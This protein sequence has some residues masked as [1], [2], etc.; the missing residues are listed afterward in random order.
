M[1]HSMPS[2]PLAVLAALTW[3]GSAHSDEK[4]NQAREAS[5]VRTMAEAEP[6]S[7]TV[8][9]LKEV[10]VRGSKW[11]YL[12]VLLE[13]PEGGDVIV[14]LGRAD[15]LSELGIR[16]GEQL[17]GEGHSITL[18]DNQVVMARQVKV[19]DQTVKIRRPAAR[20]PGTQALPLDVESADFSGE[21]LKVKKVD[22]RDDEQSQ[23]MVVLL[24]TTTDGEEVELPV[25][26]GRFDRIKPEI[27]TGQM[28]SGQGWLTH[29]G[30]WDVMMAYEVKVGEKTYP[31]ARTQAG[32]ETSRDETAVEPADR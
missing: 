12:V 7:G 1:K 19:G 17:S 28:I 9:Q 2:L 20:L 27:Q 8:K 5:D 29:F 4:P 14:D 13:G 31:I 32:K 18:G 22:I 24:K 21:V 11:Q 10:D 26:L 6:F 23:H 15:R 16:T 3:V 25:D 30:E